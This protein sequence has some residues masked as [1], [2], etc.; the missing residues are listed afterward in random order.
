MNGS[1]EA[2]R[3]ARYVSLSTYRRDGSPAA[4]PVWFAVRD[5]RGYFMTT[6]GTAKVRRL[7]RDPRVTLAPSG[8]RG[9]IR[10]E[11]AEGRARLLEG[12]E[13]ELGRRAIGVKYGWQAALV[14]VLVRLSRRRQVYYEVAAAGVESAA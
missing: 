4:T 8:V 2:L 6:A 3:S 10:G 1:F 12:G 13:A 5:G 9:A 14:A 7:R 11:S